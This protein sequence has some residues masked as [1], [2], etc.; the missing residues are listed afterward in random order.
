MRINNI[1]SFPFCK[2]TKF[3]KC[4]LHSKGPILWNTFQA[5]RTVVSK[6]IG[7][8]TTIFSL[9]S[10]KSRTYH[11]RN[12]KEFFDFTECFIYLNCSVSRNSI[13][14]KKSYTHRTFSLLM[15]SQESDEF[16]CDQ[17]QGEKQKENAYTHD[18]FFQLTQKFPNNFPA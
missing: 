13:N 4:S 16:T 17:K 2:G 3:T 7:D 11:P 5:E 14:Q 10:M 12:R 15:K 1:L 18:D 8:T 6:S 9:H